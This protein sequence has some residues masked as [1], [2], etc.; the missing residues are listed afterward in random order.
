MNSSS[1]KWL[2]AGGVAYGALL[3]SVAQ[4]QTSDDGVAAIEEVVVTGSRIARP[5]YV[6]NSPIVSVGQAA[7]ENT[8]QVTV[9]KSLSQMPQFTG[10]FGQGN[11]GSTSTGLSIHHI[12]T[13]ECI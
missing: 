11:T 2:M 7:I 13:T 5:D 9:E 6:A 1:L 4:A 8:G 12:S 10:S 3:A